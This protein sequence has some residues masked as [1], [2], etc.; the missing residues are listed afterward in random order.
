M[1]I[2]YLGDMHEDEKYTYFIDLMNWY[3]GSLSR[4]QTVWRKLLAADYFSKRAFIPDNDRI[5]AD[6]INRL[7]TDLE[8]CAAQ[9]RQEQAS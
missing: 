3:Y 7:T 4:A 6:T 2:P 8:I 5:M 9:A 1:R